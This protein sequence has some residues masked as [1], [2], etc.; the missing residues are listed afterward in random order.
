VQKFQ[1]HFDL[2]MTVDAFEPK[3]FSFTKFSV[4]SI[5]YA[6]DYFCSIKKWS[7]NKSSI[8]F[9]MQFEPNSGVMWF[10]Y[11]EVIF[12]HKQSTNECDSK[13]L[14]THK[15]TIIFHTNSRNSFST[16]N[17]RLT[18]C[19]MKLINHL[20]NIKFANKVFVLFYI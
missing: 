13:F 1:D 7:M 10:F 6:L 3:S 5:R 20:K 16:S 11:T 4:C 19:T 2:L 17:V 9:N 14:S 15:S 12:K 8:T 18:K